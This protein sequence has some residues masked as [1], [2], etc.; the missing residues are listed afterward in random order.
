MATKWSAWSARFS[1]RA[2]RVLASRG[3][4][5]DLITASF[6]AHFHGALCCG[7][8][9][10]ASLRLAQAEVMREHPHP[11]YWAAFTLHGRW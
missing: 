3:P 10:A 9:P 2:R 4:V 6:M 1:S 5:D 11:F 8:A 7:I